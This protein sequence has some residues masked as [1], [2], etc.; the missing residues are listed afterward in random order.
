MPEDNILVTSLNKLKHTVVET[1]WFITIG[2]FL[3][4]W[5]LLAP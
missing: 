1:N 2:I 4:Q 3:I 5:R